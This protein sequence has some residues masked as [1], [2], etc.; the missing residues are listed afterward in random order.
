MAPT[1]SRTHFLGAEPFH[2]VA[3]MTSVATGE[4]EVG[5]TSHG[6]VA[7]GTLECKAFADGTLDAT[8]LAAAVA[9]VDS[10]LNALMRVR[11]TGDKLQNFGPFLSQAPAVQDFSIALLKIVKLLGIGGVQKPFVPVM[12]IFLPISVVNI[13]QVPKA[14]VIR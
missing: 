1:T 2:H 4:T 8:H 9:A 13:R 7:D 11:G 14:E 10:K 5:G 6:H 3:G 12:L